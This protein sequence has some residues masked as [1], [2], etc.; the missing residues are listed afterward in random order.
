M[1]K[2]TVIQDSNG[3]IIDSEQKVEAT[4]IGLTPTIKIKIDSNNHI[5][6]VNSHIALT[7]NNPG[8]E[9]D[10]IDGGVF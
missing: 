10:I 7:T 5:N 9:N 6:S 2:I 1:T 3:H 8:L 4:A